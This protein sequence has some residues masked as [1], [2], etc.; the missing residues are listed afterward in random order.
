MLRA[1]ALE[2][3]NLIPFLSYLVQNDKTKPTGFHTNAT[4]IGGTVSLINTGGA[5]IFANNPVYWDAPK[6]DGGT[7][8]GPIKG[9]PDGII[10]PA[11]RQL[12]M[13]DEVDAIEKEIDDGTDRRASIKKALGTRRRVIGWALNN[14]RPGEQL[15]VILKK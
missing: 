9:H 8:C 14:A 3:K 7:E 12:T 15:D 2:I 4:R 10:Y 5:D 13:E 11:I 6:K 1:S